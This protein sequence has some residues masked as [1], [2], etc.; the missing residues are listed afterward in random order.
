MRRTTTGTK[1][2]ASTLWTLGLATIQELE[3][4]LGILASAKE[5]IYGCVFGRDS[6]ISA[7]KLLRAYR[8][9]QDP[10]FLALVKKILLSLSDL[11][12]RSINIESGEQPGKII[13]EYRPENHD[14]LT[15][16]LSQPWYVY[17][18]N[19]MRN[20]D[21]VDSTPLFL[22][23][24]YRYYQVSGDDETFTTL[25]PAVYKALDW[26]LEFADSNGDGFVDYTFD[27]N[28]KYGGLKTQSWMD[29][30]ESVFHEDGTPVIYPIAPAE[31]QAY[32]YLA[33]QLWSDYFAN[34]QEPLSKQLAQRAKELK[35]KFNQVFVCSG[36]EFAIASALDGNLRAL[37]SVRSSMGHVLWAAQTI[38]LDGIQNSI[39]NDVFVP[40]LVNRLMAKDLFV[41]EAGLRTLSSNSSQFDPASYHNGSIW[42]HD[43]AMVAEGFENFGYQK[44]ARALRASLKAAWQHFGSPIELFVY[45]DD[46]FQEY[47]SSSGQKACSKQAWSAASM[48]AEL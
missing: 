40:Q 17:P 9:N 11:Q 37:T 39:L 45:N 32:A 4:D 33:L 36:Q 46:G 25:K 24:V 8:K 22:I 30:Q 19:I 10:Y 43:T 44:Q 26:L 3:S 15:Q 6:L 34:N 31:V 20:Y 5:E 13:H 27:E 48:V 18:D 38:E 21:S 23:A 1:S 2:L 12:G 29:S 28:R 42:P 41:P 16:N 7:L 47:C 35:E 14:H